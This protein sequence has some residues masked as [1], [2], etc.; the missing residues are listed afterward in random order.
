MQIADLADQFR[1]LYRAGNSGLVVMIHMVRLC[2]GISVE[3]RSK[4]IVQQWLEGRLTVLFK[5]DDFVL[6]GIERMEIGR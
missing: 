2:V 4:V 3:C 1:D 5:C 6:T